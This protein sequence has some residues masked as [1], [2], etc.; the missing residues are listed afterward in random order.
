MSEEW[1][2]RR[3]PKSVETEAREGEM[4]GQRKLKGKGG[5]GEN[6]IVL[7][8]LDWHLVGRSANVNNRIEHFVVTL[9]FLQS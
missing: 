6:E 1:N 5:K 2:D 7:M 8:R 3:P 4:Q 9:F